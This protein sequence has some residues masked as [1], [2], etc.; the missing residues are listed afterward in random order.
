MPFF[1]PLP[2]FQ[3]VP[4]WVMVLWL[5][6]SFLGIMGLILLERQKVL[7]SD[8]STRPKCDPS[9]A[10]IEVEHPMFQRLH[11][12]RGEEGSLADLDVLF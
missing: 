9:F 10:N 6:V 4:C 12:K 11:K 5:G 2:P 3:V 8:L 7:T 1:H